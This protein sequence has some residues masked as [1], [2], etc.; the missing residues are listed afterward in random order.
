MRMDDLCDALAGEGLLPEPALDIVQDARV[1]RVGLVKDVLQ[2][3]I[4]L[5][6]TVTK[7]LCEDPSTICITSLSEDRRY[8]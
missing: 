6:Q 2:R 4:R 8:R 3:K 1:R 7:V 5:S